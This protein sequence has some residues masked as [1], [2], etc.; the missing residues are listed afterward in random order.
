MSVIAVTS[1]TICARPELRAR[2]EGLLAPKHRIRFATFTKPG[3]EDLRAF[4]AG[5]DGALIGRE[6]IDEPLLAGLPDLR[7][8]SVYGVGFDNVDAAACAKRGVALLVAP[9]VNADAV[10]E[11][12]LGLMLA[13]LRNIARND[14]LLHEGVWNK[15]GGRTLQGKTVAILGCGAV[16]SRVGRLLKAFSCHIVLND[17]LAKAELAAELGGCELGIEAA[18]QIADIVTVHVPLTAV[19]RG[20]F[21]EKA[22][23][24]MK[25]GAVLVN[26]SRGPVVRLAALK[27]ALKTGQV[28]GAGLDVFEN[29]PILDAELFAHP[30]VVG[31]PHTAGNAREAV[32]A[33]TDAAAAKLRDYL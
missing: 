10:A 11:H 5:A 24:Q 27:K 28:A 22:F 12:T 4:L 17:I 23:G 1:A 18:L 25:P 21:D 14:R 31:T 2:V 6:V 32:E 8:V 15:D 26:T 20:L 7:A 29:E 33:M 13:V 19:T 9:G 16:G 30:G 3:R